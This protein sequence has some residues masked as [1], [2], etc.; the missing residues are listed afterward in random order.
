MLGMPYLSIAMR[1]EPHA[2]RETGVLLRVVADVFEDDRVN[3]PATEDL[4][5]TG[6]LADPTRGGACAITFPGAAEHA[7]HVDLAAGLDE[8]EVTRAKANRDVL[9]EE[10]AKEECEH[11]F[12]LGES[13][14]FI[15]EEALELKEHRRMR[16]VVVRDG[17][18][19]PGTR[20][21]AAA[22]ASA[23]RGI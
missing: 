3:H 13:H 12:E 18:P 17:R 2:E 21:R 14:V 6:A 20:W 9:V 19:H 22:D 8:G 10:A 15:D 1:I 23:S 16:G 11:S 4:H 7:T 5:P